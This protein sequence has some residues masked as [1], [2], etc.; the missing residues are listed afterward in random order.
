MS[1]L[2]AV[3]AQAQTSRGTVTGTVT[4]PSGGVVEG[5]SVELLHIATQAPNGIP[6]GQISYSNSPGYS[7][8]VNFMEDFSG[9]PGRL[10]RTI[11]GAVFH[12]N[13]FR[14]S[15]FFQDM[16]KAAPSL[17][18]T[19]GLRYENFGQPV[20]AL[21]YPAFTGFD[22]NLFTQPNRIDADK[23]VRLCFRVRVDACVFFRLAKQMAGKPSN[24]VEG[25]LSDQL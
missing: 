6:L 23:L 1:L 3:L 7:A 19:L 21:P 13:Q 10:Q 11:G 17:T 15:Y 12:P 20:N 24:G 16:W 5:A 4:D 18:L 2:L 14:Q 8:F 25:R 9:Q 22:P